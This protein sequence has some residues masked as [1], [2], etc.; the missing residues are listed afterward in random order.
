[1][2]YDYEDWT[3]SLTERLLDAD[4]S[5][6]DDVI[7]NISETDYCAEFSDFI[8][9]LVDISQTGKITVN[10]DG[11]NDMLA[12]KGFYKT[13]SADG[14]QLFISHFSIN[15]GYMVDWSIDTFH[16]YIKEGFATI[17][18]LTLPSTFDRFIDVNVIPRL[19]NVDE[20]NPPS[21]IEQILPL[22]DDGDV[23]PF[24]NGFYSIRHNKILPK[25]PYKSTSSP[26][27]VRF[28]PKA[29]NNPTIRQRY[30]DMMCGDEELL[31][32]LFEQIGYILYARKHNNP[33]F[34]LLVGETG[35]NGKSTVLNM[36]ESII[37]VKNIAKLSM[38]EM[39]NEFQLATAHGKYLCMSHDT[40][41]GLR[42]RTMATADA[43]EFIKKATAGEPFTFNPKYGK[44]FEGYG[45][46]KFIF[47]SN[48]QI[49]F[50]GGADGGLE[51]RMTV[52]PF[53]AKFEE[54]QQVAE[55][56][57]SQEAVEWF[58]MQAL[59]SYMCYIHRAYSA[60]ESE[61]I[62]NTAVKGRFMTSKK[63]AQ[64]KKEQLTA[65]ST[66]LDWISSYHNL[67]IDDVAAIRAL[68]IAGND[69]YDNYTM[70]CKQSNRTPMTL[71]KFNRE[72]RNRYGLVRRRTTCN[73]YHAYRYDLYGS[74]PED[75]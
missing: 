4:T 56:F 46:K 24:S 67:D 16:T 27:N 17:G 45:P 69:I 7:S 37:S 28:N 3:E 25:T 38:Y 8:T 6:E 36:L 73:G 41:S 22:Y 54:D 9:T 70:F 15:K 23:I 40:T 20:I 33:H 18:N 75:Y 53:N 48:S 62:P 71:N 2:R 50:G 43:K 68:F 14:S 57:K 64:A 19:T 5:S 52:I 58:A 10:T 74:S 51:R 1:M 72:V 13:R 39:S 65:Q 44:P 49:N 66:I 29:L 30:L 55:E 32:D 11:L 12:K 35:C 21:E 26:L 60:G 34:T 31:E 61:F 47:A 63:A 42:D 59:L